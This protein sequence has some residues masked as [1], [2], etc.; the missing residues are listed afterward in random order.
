MAAALSLRKAAVRQV[1]DKGFFTEDAKRMAEMPNMDKDTGKGCHPKCSYTCEQE[2]CEATCQPMVHAGPLCQTRCPAIGDA[3]TNCRQECNEP[4]C[5]VICPEEKRVKF[6]RPECMTVCNAP[7]CKAFCDVP[8]G[9]HSVCAE[10][11]YEWKCKDPKTCAQPKCTL[12]CD[13]AVTCPMGPNA[14]NPSLPEPGENSVVVSTGEAQL[15]E[16]APKS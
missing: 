3:R 16:V 15:G 14:L 7:K 11:K 4:D 13:G 5:V 2:E 12:T 8:E 6:P 1:P 9:C 10:P